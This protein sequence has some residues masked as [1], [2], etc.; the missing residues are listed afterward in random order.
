M[1]TVYDHA[2]L[3]AFIHGQPRAERLLGRFIEHDPRSRAY[4][5]ADRGPE[6]AYEGVFHRRHSNILD[7]GQ[8][9][10]CTGN[11]GTGMLAC[12]PFALSRPVRGLGLDEAYAVK[13][14]SDA[15][16]RDDVPG[17]YP[18]M[19]TGSSGLAIAKV[20]RARGLIDGYQHA[21]SVTGLLTALQTAPVII[22]TVWLSGMD[23]PDS[24]GFVPVAGSVQGGHEY[25]CREFEPGSTLDNGVITLDNSW[26]KGWGDRGRF[27]MH[28]RD[29]AYLLGQQG[30][31]VAPVPHRA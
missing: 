18:P 15:T 27:R 26:G 21:F 8:L 2:P 22:G 17:S 12:E 1:T 10:S 28:V 6:H 3:I 16:H 24:R 13:L 20:L 19:D 11:A 5:T 29:M 30:D 23:Q 25:L 4:A 7:Q 9:G 31:V 14:Y